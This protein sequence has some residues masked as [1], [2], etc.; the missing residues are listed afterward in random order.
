MSN[1]KLQDIL[2][3]AVEAVKS[4]CGR[5]V[6]TEVSKETGISVSRLRR[7][8]DNGFVIRPNG[9]AGRHRE[10]TKLT[11]FEDLINEQYLRKGITNSNVITERI[12]LEGYDGGTTTVKNYI[13]THQNLVPAQRIVA[14]STPNRGRR[15]DTLPGEMFQMDWGFVNVDDGGGSTWQ[16]ACFVMV[17][18]HCGFRYVEFFTSARQE[19]LFTAMIHA[20]S[21]MG[22]PKVVLTDN[23]KSVV[24]R[25]LADGTPVFNKEYDE[26]QKTIGFSTRLCKVAHPFTKGR[27]ER[28]VRYVK[29]NFILSRPFLNLTDLN[30]SVS[31]WCNVR[32]SA[33]LRGTVPVETHYKKEHFSA[34]PPDDVILPYVAPLRRISYDGFVNYENRQYGVPISYTGKLVRVCRIGDSLQI[35]RPDTNEVIARHKVDWVKAP[36]CCIG[37]WDEPV[38]KPSEPVKSTIR[39]VRSD[40]DRKRFNRFSILSGE[41]GK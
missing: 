25:R 23:M 6:L 9:N 3:Q 4:R 19:N 37:Q 39:F 30:A 22:V 27:V 16:C 21:V 24:I 35:S 31:E 5:V 32:N 17:C 12:R 40:V 1:E 41:D 26:F 18:H 36:K 15:Y 8:R 28:L 14:I 29:G 38:E 7:L 20:F 34:L 2:T 11:R 33:E 10:V 13:R